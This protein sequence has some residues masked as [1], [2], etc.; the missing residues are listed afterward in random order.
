[1]AVGLDGRM[2]CLTYGWM[3]GWMGGVWESMFEVSII[4]LVQ[5]AAQ[6]VRPV[7]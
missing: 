5:A 7:H 4:G 1:M 3:G 2:I 6:L